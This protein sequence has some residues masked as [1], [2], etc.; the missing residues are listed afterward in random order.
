MCR[1][2]KIRTGLWKV[3]NARLTTL[4]FISAIFCFSNPCDKLGEAWRSIFIHPS[5]QQRTTSYPIPYLQS[6][7]QCL[8]KRGSQE[9]PVKIEYL[10]KSRALRESRSRDNCTEKT[11][12]TVVQA[13]KRW[14]P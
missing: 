10:K 7:T 1:G 8:H 11:R 9:T 6:I 14:T 12:I 13:R 2:D 5:I 4:D 3:S